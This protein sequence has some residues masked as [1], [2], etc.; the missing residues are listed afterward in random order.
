[1][2]QQ[3]LEK[4]W[5]EHTTAEFVKRDVEATMATMTDDAYINI[6]PLNINARGKDVVRA[7]YRDILIPSVPDDLHA[8]IVNRVIG[9]RH[10]VDEVS[11]TLTHSTRMDWLLPNV[12]PTF[13]K[14]EFDHIVVIEFRGNKIVG[15]RVYWDQ[16]TVLRQA[17]LLKD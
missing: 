17:G 16:A 3:E 1:L 15:E 11:F 12:P 7:F 5:H 6:V 14:I 13:K 8:T 9:E 4:L 10:L 2:T